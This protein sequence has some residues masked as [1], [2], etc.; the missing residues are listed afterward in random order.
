[1]C[2]H[3]FNWLAVSL[4][5]VL[6]LGVGCSSGGEVE[7]EEI[8]EPSEEET[9]EVAA[10]SATDEDGEWRF[11]VHPSDPI[12]RHL[13]QII[14][15]AEDA[16]DGLPCRIESS[17]GGVT[18]LEYDEE[19][20]RSRIVSELPPSMPSELPISDTV[21]AYH[22]DE[23]GELERL[24]ISPVEDEETNE[25]VDISVETVDRNDHGH[26]LRH[27]YGGSASYEIRSFYAEE[28]RLTHVETVG[29]ESGELGNRKEFTYD[30]RGRLLRLEDDHNLDGEANKVV[31]YVYGDDGRLQEQVMESRGGGAM[32]DQIGA[33][34]EPVVL[35]YIYGCDD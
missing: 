12:S 15:P 2:A 4:I 31:T 34:Q 23:E 8:A 24:V 27:V 20:S 10:E 25:D 5:Y 13:P 7:P 1:M 18:T 29:E 16:S 6:V 17:Q 28:Q 21:Y 22:Y 32:L 3:R 30:E 19:G 26:P 11:V 35:T 33:K 9:G 14:A